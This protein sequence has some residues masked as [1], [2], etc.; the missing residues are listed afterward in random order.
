MAQLLSSA[1]GLIELCSVARGLTVC[2]AVVKR[3][4][5]QVVTATT[6]HPGKYLILFRGGVDEVSESLQ[7]GRSV[8]GE[9]LV[10][11][12]F[13][14]QPHPGLNSVL[15]AP[16]NVP[17][18]SLG[19]I[20]TF[21]AASAI[22]GADSALKGGDV[23]ALRLRLADGLGGKAYFIFTGALHDVDAAMAFGIEAAGAGLLAGSE[24]IANP[25]PDFLRALE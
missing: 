9:T 12:V 16:V 7:R 17:A 5:V 25:H 8:A 3:A 22:R 10:D 20:E 21:S 18:R 4:E 19:I 15:L 1:L 13:L 11:E 23:T 2:D 14:A 24:V 6:V